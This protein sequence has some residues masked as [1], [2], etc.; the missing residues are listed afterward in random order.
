MYV[1]QSSERKVTNKV[2]LNGYA[3][4]KRGG[5]G[6]I[7]YWYCDQRKICS[8]SII[9]KKGAFTCNSSN[10]SDSRRSKRGWGASGNHESHP[11]DIERLKY[12][13]IILNF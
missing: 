13:L 9:E 6:N 2:A 10:I 8:A 4:T 5:K 12:T 7:S 3:Y 11:P 1:C